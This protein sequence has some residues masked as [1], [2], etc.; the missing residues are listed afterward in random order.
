[1]PTC[2]MKTVWEVVHPGW[3]ICCKGSH[4]QFNRAMPILVCVFWT[5]QNF[6]KFSALKVQIFLHTDWAKLDIFVT[7]NVQKVTPIF[8]LCKPEK[9]QVSMQN[10]GG[11]WLVRINNQDQS[12]NGCLVLHIN[13]LLGRFTRGSPEVTPEWLVLKEL[14]FPKVLFW[15][16]NW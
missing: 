2:L 14:L 13:E 1:M 15:K 5:P 16:L 3:P 12:L 7:W 6:F 10:N 9:Y 11:F 4:V 8:R